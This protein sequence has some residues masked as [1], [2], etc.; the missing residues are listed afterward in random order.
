MWK[1]CL[2]WDEIPK[3]RIAMEIGTTQDELGPKSK[4][5]WAQKG[6]RLIM[7]DLDSYQKPTKSIQTRPSYIFAC[8]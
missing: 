5:G 2:F 3:Q 1:L 4:S 7:V 8:S 6:P